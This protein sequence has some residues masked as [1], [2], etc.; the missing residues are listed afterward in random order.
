MLQSYQ[1][2]PT[3][4]LIKRAASDLCFGADTSVAWPGGRL[5][6]RLGFGLQANAPIPHARPVDEQEWRLASNVIRAVF[7]GTIGKRPG[8]N[9]CSSARE[10]PVDA[11]APGEAPGSLP[12][13]VC[14]PPACG[15]KAHAPRRGRQARLEPLAGRPPR[16]AMFVSQFTRARRSRRRRGAA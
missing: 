6:P 9:G 1:H 11:R 4:R 14:V 16:C 10:R 12:I 5:K 7:A 8:C 13:G 15:G 2:G 3:K